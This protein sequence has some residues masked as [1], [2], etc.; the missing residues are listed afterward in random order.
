[1]RAVCDT[2]LNIS[3][4]NGCQPQ[5]CGLFLFC[6]AIYF[7]VQLLH[8]IWVILKLLIELQVRKIQDRGK[9]FLYFLH[10]SIFILL[11]HFELLSN[12]KPIFPFVG[13]IEDFD[14]FISWTL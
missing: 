1:M 10:A 9:N 3:V 6:Q 13:K 11:S 12:G 8:H 4:K 2:V 5:K 14:L 7:L